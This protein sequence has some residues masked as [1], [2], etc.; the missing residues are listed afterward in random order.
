M[1]SRRT[2]IAASQRGQ[3]DATHDQCG[4]RTPAGHSFATGRTAPPKVSIVR[5]SAYCRCALAVGAG[6]M[7]YGFEVANSP[8]GPRDGVPAEELIPAIA[9]LPHRAPYDRH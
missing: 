5:L 6:M 2:F 7:T 4:D 1:E 9:F 8:T 3:L